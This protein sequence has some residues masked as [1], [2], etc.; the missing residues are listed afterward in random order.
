LSLYQAEVIPRERNAQVL[1][2]RYFD[3]VLERFLFSCDFAFGRSNPAVHGDLVG[4]IL[5]YWSPGLRNCMASWS[6]GGIL[7]QT[8]GPVSLSL[9]LRVATILQRLF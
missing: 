1:F 2:P 8:L 5:G 6:R 7:R 9:L 3:Y 4:R